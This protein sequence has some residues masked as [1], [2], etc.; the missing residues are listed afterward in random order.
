MHARDESARAHAEAADLRQRV[1]VLEQELL[2]HDLEVPSEPE[3]RAA[4]LSKE[5]LPALGAAPEGVSD[6][7]TEHLPAKTAKEQDES[8]RLQAEY[9]AEAAAHEVS[10]SPGEDDL[11]VWPFNFR[12]LQQARIHVI[13]QDPAGCYESRIVHLMTMHACRCYQNLQQVNWLKSSKSDASC[14]GRSQMHG[15][16][17]QSTAPHAW[18]QSKREK[19]MSRK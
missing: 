15:A 8:D 3:E 16:G 4:P 13:C 17:M 1:S 7:Y 11:Q 12:E 6:V 10:G 5:V 18:L 14:S 9:A 2:R 19:T